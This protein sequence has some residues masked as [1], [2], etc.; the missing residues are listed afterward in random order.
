MDKEQVLFVLAA[1]MLIGS[2]RIDWDYVYLLK[3]I[4][5]KQT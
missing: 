2:I 5:A 3:G 4:R 1:L